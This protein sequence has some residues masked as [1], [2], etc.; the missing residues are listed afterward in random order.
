MAPP[1]N[2]AAPLRIAACDCRGC[3]SHGSWH[4]CCPPT[5]SSRIQQ[6]PLNLTARLVSSAP[7][8]PGPSRRPPVF[9]G[10]PR[11][12]RVRPRAITV[13]QL[14]G[15]PRHA[16]GRRTGAA[17]R[18]AGGPGLPAMLVAPCRWTARPPCRFRQRPLQRPRTI[19][20]PEPAV[21]KPLP[22]R[23]PDLLSSVRH[24]E[25]VVSGQGLEL[26]AQVAEDA[27]HVGEDDVNGLTAHAQSSNDRLRLDRR[28]AGQAGRH[29]AVRERRGRRGCPRWSMW[30][31]RASIP[32]SRSP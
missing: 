31:P 3:P 30:G 21:P 2:R 8:R 20:H 24:R 14:P 23:G 27:N 11:T 28:E 32:K 26:I 12:P 19:E 16:A 1:R 25:E 4:C 5:P 13:E 6:I 15:R 7:A 29:V 18:Q 9:P 10:P 17:H 22:H